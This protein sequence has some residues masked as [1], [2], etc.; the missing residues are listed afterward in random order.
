MLP[1]DPAVAIVDEFIAG[2]RK[3]FKP[4]DAVAPP[5]GGGSVDVW[6]FAGDGALPD[7]SV[8]KK[9][10]PF[11]WVRLDRRY[12]VRESQFPSAFVGVEKCAVPD[13]QRAVAIEVGV[14]RC[15][16][17]DAR[18]KRSVLEDEATIGIDDSWRVDLALCI[19]EKALRKAG[20]AVAVDTVAP[21]GPEGGLV[22]WSGMA[23]VQ[24]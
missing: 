21:M 18:P 4:D 16:T 24:Y 11:L 15:T 3:A 8:C 7:A 20:H 14:A 17:M 6:T 9:G 1:V 10:E 19:A 2:M 13:I 12:R 5:I 22:A 23:Y